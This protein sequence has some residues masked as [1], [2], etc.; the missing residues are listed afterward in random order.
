LPC[1][2][3]T[4]Y[5]T[6]DGLANNAVRSITIDG[7]GHKW[8][9]ISAGGVSEFDGSNWTTYTTTDGLADNS[10]YAISIDGAG[11]K[12]FGTDGGVSEYFLGG[13]WFRLSLPFVV[14]GD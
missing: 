4:I 7:A 14:R 5:T 8:F 13:S 6:S 3:W 1:N 9:G 2:T 11:H 10:I 12:W